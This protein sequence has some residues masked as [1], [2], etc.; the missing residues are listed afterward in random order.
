MDLAAGIVV[1]EGA[2]GDLCERHG[3][4]RLALFGSAL[5]D[6]LRADSDIDLLGRPDVRTPRDLS[7]YFRDDVLASA[8]TLYGVA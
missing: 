4:Q 8:Q 5:R 2:L 1:D 6:E 3:I 7:R